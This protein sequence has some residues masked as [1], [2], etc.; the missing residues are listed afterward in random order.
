[1]TPQLPAI[2][3]L[4]P[5]QVQPGRRIQNSQLQA[6]MRAAQGVRPLAHGRLSV[7]IKKIDVAAPETLSCCL[8]PRA[9]RSVLALND[10][11]QQI[12]RWR[13]IHEASQKQGKAIASLDLGVSNSLPLRLVD[14]S[15]VTQTPQNRSRHQFNR[16]KHV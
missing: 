6:A 14:A 9:V 2:S 4:D 3:G 1:M 10:P 15:A 8:P 16:K 5:N 11:E 13:E 7:E 12:R